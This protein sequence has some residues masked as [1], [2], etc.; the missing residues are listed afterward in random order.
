MNVLDKET[1]TLF[2]SQQ[3]HSSSFTLFV[4]HHHLFLS[5]LFVLTPSS[6]FI[7]ITFLSQCLSLSSLFGILYPSFDPQTRLNSTID[8]E[9]LRTCC[10]ERPTRAL[11][12]KMNDMNETIID[13]CPFSRMLRRHPLPANLHRQPRSLSLT[14]CKVGY[15]GSVVRSFLVSV[16]RR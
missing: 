15:S 5:S 4:L 1:E 14:G 6:L 8:T 10:T 13:G 3:S 9:T 2:M 12:I 11:R 16:L 7:L